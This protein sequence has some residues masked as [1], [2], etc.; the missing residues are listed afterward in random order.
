MNRPHVFLL[1]LVVVL[2]TAT[3]ARADVYLAALFG[4]ATGGALDGSK[5]TYGGQLGILGSGMTGVE[6]DYGFTTKTKG[7]H[8]GDNFRTLTGS[9]L[10][11]P[12]AIGSQKVRPYVSAGGG[13]ISGVSELKHLFIGDDSVESTTV[14]T[15][16]GGIFAY[17][18]NQIGIRLDAR[19]MKALIDAD[20]DFGDTKSHFVRVSG[21][22]VV[23]F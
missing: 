4:V 22:L 2:G 13:I 8:G 1:A 6:G 18:S 19:Y 12:M 15:A 23:R 3:T 11:A 10:I 17:L 16:G 14:V 7:G 9:V 20:P 5:L 21:G